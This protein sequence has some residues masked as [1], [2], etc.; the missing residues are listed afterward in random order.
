M[1]PPHPRQTAMQFTPEQLA[2]ATYKDGGYISSGPSPDSD[3]STNKWPANHIISAIGYD[4]T[5]GKVYVTGKSWKHMYEIELTAA[6]DRGA[7][8]VTGSCGLVNLD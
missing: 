2:T 7:D 4:K 6:P 1:T 8:F 5:T 3:P